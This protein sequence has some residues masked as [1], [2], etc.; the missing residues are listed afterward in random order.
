MRE[1]R[2]FQLGYKLWLA[3]RGKEIVVCL[4][5]RSY[6]IWICLLASRRHDGISGFFD[7]KIA[8]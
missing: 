8:A 6:T 4:S 3:N 5:A 1:S 7:K 2:Q